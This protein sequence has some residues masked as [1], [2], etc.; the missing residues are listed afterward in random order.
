[1]SFRIISFVFLLCIAS[2]SGCARQYN[3]WC[4][5][6]FDADE[7]I[8]KI[9]LYDRCL[10]E[11]KLSHDD[12]LY[13]LSDRSE[14]YAEIHEYGLAIDDIHEYVQLKPN[15]PNAYYNLGTYWDKLGYPHNAIPNYS[16]A[17]QL[18]ANDWGAYLKRASSYSFESKWK[19]AIE[20]LKQVV[21]LKPKHYRAHIRLGISYAQ[22]G[23]YENA[24]MVLDKGIQISPEKPDGYAVKGMTYALSGRCEL[25]DELFCKTDEIDSN[26]YEPLAYRAYCFE[27]NGQKSIAKQNYQKA[28]KIFPT[29]SF[30]LERLATLLLTTPPDENMSN[31]QQAIILAKQLVSKKKIPNPEALEFLAA[32]Y[33]ELN[34]FKDAV[35]TQERALSSVDDS[36]E[37]SRI[38]EL[39]TRY[40][41]KQKHPTL[42]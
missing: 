26:R 8:P 20:D 39:I 31:K 3:V 41:S 36:D 4:Y 32:V 13:M 5:D 24:I 34:M 35:D 11:N 29:N 42:F 19:E 16:K 27:Q 15:N 33:A 14:A 28:L 10:A 12:Y 7:P 9:H 37:V 38:K 18:D 25:A 6:A 21:L 23:Q 1:M 30:S 40:E 22:L 17:I 2:M